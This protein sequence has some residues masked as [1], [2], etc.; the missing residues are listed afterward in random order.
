MRN[1]YTTAKSDYRLPVGV[2]MDVALMIGA[3][4]N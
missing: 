2:T 1:A 4:L 3:F